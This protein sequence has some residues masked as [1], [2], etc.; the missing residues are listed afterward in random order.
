MENSNTQEEINQLIEQMEKSLDAMLSATTDFN[1]AGLKLKEHRKE[2]KA[3]WANDNDARFNTIMSKSRNI[4]ILLYN[5]S[6]ID[7]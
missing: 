5:T 3:A 1:N 6:K 4:D 2:N 7:K